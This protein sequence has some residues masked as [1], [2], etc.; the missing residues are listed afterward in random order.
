MCLIKAGSPAALISVYAPINSMRLLT[1]V[2]GMW[3]DRKVL[4]HKHMRLIKAG[5]PAALIS[6]YALINPSLR[7]VK[8]QESTV[9]SRRVGGG[10]GVIANHTLF[11]CPSIHADVA[12]FI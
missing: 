5:S 2:Y 11:A 8:R 1:R 3:K 9:S 7:Y 12:L 4:Y 6:V 10:G